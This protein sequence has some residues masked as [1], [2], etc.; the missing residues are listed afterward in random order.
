M[1]TSAVEDYLKC[2]YQA[3][4]RTT[5]PVATGLIASQLGVAPGTVTAMVK[6]LAE[7]GLLDY[8]PYAG[9]RLTAAGVKLA[10]HVLRRHRVIE[11]FLVEILGMN[12]SEVHEDAERLEHSV[13]DRVLDRMDEMLGRPQ[14]DPHGDPI[15]SPRGVLKERDY[16]SLVTCPLRTPLRIAR[17]TDQAADFLRLLERHGVMPGREVEVDSRDEAADTVLVRPNQGK[18][19]SLGF[20]PAS[21]VQVTPRE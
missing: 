7:S 10:A 13:S 5:E 16:P 18:A 8:E 9:V 12:W 6:T 2:I 17:V 11:L 1:P 21:A 15:P 19:L 4:A 3:Q 14:V 20:R